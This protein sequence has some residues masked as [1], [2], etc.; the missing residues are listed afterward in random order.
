MNQIA[1]QIPLRPISL[2]HSHRLVRFGKRISRIKTEAAKDFE[3]EFL[4]HLQEY[5]G[6]RHHIIDGYDPRKH[7][8]ELE[9]YF[10]MNEGEYFTKP[11]KGFKTINKRCMDLDNM[12]KVANDQIF[13]WLG[14]DDS[15]VTKITAQ[16]IPTNDEATMVFRISLASIPELFVISH[17]EV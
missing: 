6:L 1:F 8:I 9:A 16:K 11:K 14:I 17:L 5:N 13:N 7:S 10:Y 15:Q 12:I 3:S 2:N 4:F